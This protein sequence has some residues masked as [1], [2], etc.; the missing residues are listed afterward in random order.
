M[1]QSAVM[2]LFAT[3]M[4]VGC[5]SHTPPSNPDNLCSIFQEKP[6]WYRQA[7]K[8]QKRWQASIPV[9]MSIMYQESAFRHDVRPPRR[10]FL[11]IPLP[12]KTS[13]YG[14]A[15]AQD[16]VWG[17]YLKEAGGWFSS[18]ES[19]ADAI[20]FIGWYNHKS[21]QKNGITLEQADQLYLN[22]HEGWW[23]YKRGGWKSKEAVKTIA[24]KVYQR[25]RK[26]DAQL[27]NCVL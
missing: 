1:I 27:K 23:G 4:L 11:F 12:R 9:M 14:Y 16:A 19:F 6:G 24:D 15:Q 20:D 3:V 18:R 8:S 2:L 26:Y 13:A 7:K 10:W 25:A 21:R 17:E 5:D 22:Y